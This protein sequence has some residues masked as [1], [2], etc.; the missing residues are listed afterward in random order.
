MIRMRTE[1]IILDLNELLRERGIEI[2]GD[3][4]ASVISDYGNHV[5][6]IAMT[7]ESELPRL[8]LVGWLAAPCR[9]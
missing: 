5:L 4:S 3:V 7:R 6:T 2:W 8:R 9:T 1:A